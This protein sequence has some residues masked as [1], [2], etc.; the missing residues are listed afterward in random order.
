MDYQQITSVSLSRLVELDCH[1]FDVFNGIL[2][3]P[4]PKSS[5]K[6]LGLLQTQLSYL[7]PRSNRAQSG[8]PEGDEFIGEYQSLM[9]QEFF[10]F[11]L[12][13]V[14]WIVN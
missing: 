1:S 14:P 4:E 2:R 7:R 3:Q 10:D 5:K 6:I 13:D 9:E 8:R 12:Y 11:V